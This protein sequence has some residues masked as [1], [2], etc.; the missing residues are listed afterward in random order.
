MEPEVPIF[1]VAAIVV[2]CFVLANIGHAN[3]PKSKTAGASW[4]AE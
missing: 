3:A 4:V 1:Y 2:L